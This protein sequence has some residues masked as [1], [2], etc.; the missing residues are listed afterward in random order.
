MTGMR[1]KP[2]VRV[3]RPAEF[4][5]RAVDEVPATGRFRRY[6]WTWLLVS[7]LAVGGCAARA[8]A[9]YEPGPPTHAL[10][11]RTDGAFADLE[12][13]IAAR[14]G[15][16]MSGFRLLD[17]NADGLRWR[18]VLIDSARY[19]IDAQYYLWYGDST[20]RLLIRHLVQAADRGVRVRL[21]VDDLNTMLEDA[22]TVTQRDE[23]VGRIDAHPNI[24]LRLFNPWKYK[25]LAARVG[26][27]M[28]RLKQVNRRM[29]NKS[30]IVDNQAVI[31]GGR[32]VGNEYMG[33]NTDFN[34]RDIDV[35]AIGPVA[36]QASAVFDNYWNS[37]WVRP[38]SLLGIYMTDDEIR[39]ALHRLDQEIEKDAVLGSFADAPGDRASE[40][41]ELERRLLAGRATVVSDRLSGLEV[42]HVMLEHVTSMMRSASSELLVENAYIIPSEIGIDMLRELDARGV[43]T[44]ILT[45][46]LASHDVP[47]VNSHYRSWRKPIVEAG[48]ELYELSHDPELASE[49]ADTSPVTA[50]LT[51]LHS[52]AMVVDRERDVIG[53]MNYDPRS[54]AINTEMGMIIDSQEL[55]HVLADAIDRDMLPSNSWQVAL[56]DDGR[57]TWINDVE[58]VGRQPARNWWQRVQDWFFRAF[59]KELY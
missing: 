6:G 32:N 26:E 21:L 43:R 56:D 40:I 15:A 8:V 51:G 36:I 47:A 39:A 58:Q 46:S 4:A 29:H 44:R 35:L 16:D 45:N 12:A 22:A 20:G 3:L 48:A 5:G 24:E 50:G 59:P 7:A 1:G 14:H 55:A 52:K 11:P 37:E 27:S 42:E 25:A 23:I 17:A 28:T 41:D 33:L 13:R 38:A 57:L 10:A 19:S 53:S 2:C 18:L 30:L 54:A 34:F 9:P 31:V 49:I